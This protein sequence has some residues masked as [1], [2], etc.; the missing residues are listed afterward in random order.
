MLPRVVAIAVDTEDDGDVLIAGRCGDDDLPGP[1]LVHMDLRLGG[2]GK[3]AGG[4]DDDVDPQ[5]FPGEV[6]GIPLSKTFT[7]DPSTVRWSPSALT[8]PAKWPRMESYL[9]GCARVVVSV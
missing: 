2:V 8:S 6:A 9:R 5:V 7:R 4:F 3:E 1:T